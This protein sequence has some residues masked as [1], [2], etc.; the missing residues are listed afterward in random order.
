MNRA[1]NLLRLNFSTF[2]KDWFRNYAYAQLREGFV[3]T[4][5]KKEI[6]YFI[7]DWL[8]DNDDIKSTTSG[9]TG[10]PKTISLKKSYVL[11][12]AKATNNFFNLK[13]GDVALL[14]LPIKY[15]AGKLMVV[16]AIE[17]G[18]DLYCVEPSLSPSFSQSFIDF[19]AMTP[20]QVTSLLAND[21]RRKLLNQ[22]DKLIIGGDSIPPTLEEKIQH[23]APEVWHTYGMTE[24]ITHI[25]L[26]KVNGERTSQ[27]F[28]PMSHVKVSLYNDNCLIVDAPSI[29][30]INLKTNDIA[31]IQADGSF[32]IVGR[33]DSVIISGGVKLFPEEIE[34][35]LS[36][37]CKFPFYFAGKKDDLL[38][39]KLIMYIES[40][41]EVDKEAL[42]KKISTKVDKYQVPKEITVVEKFLR[43]DSGKI[44]R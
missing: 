24:T 32:K 14:C 22:I 33:K 43:T 34:K 4:E 6:F 26:R 7:I 16:R 8:S 38:G 40:T 18:L 30:V 13:K 42:L 19:A 17:R 1:N 23:L 35:K 21:E 25:A 41:T 31:D 12:S 44:L 28:T 39:N 10:V 2:D 5:W 9:S 3:V 20:A 11:N 29:G 37:V 27:S 15:I 36:D